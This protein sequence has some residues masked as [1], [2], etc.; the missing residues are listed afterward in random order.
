MRLHLQDSNSDLGLQAHQDVAD[1]SAA[2]NV[3]NCLM[4]DLELE[5]SPIKLT[6]QGAR[7][8]ISNNAKQ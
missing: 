8:T 7:I 6:L 3:Q 4:L 2:A 5:L 1:V